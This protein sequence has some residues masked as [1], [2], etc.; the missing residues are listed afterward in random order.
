MTLRRA[1]HLLPQREPLQLLTI[2]SIVFVIYHWKV[3]AYTSPDVH[4]YNE[5]HGS[6]IC[7]QQLGTF[8]QL[9]SCMKEPVTLDAQF[10]ASHYYLQ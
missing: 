4:A 5:S 7:S 3:H 9:Q 6:M 1:A 10:F 8:I 2:L